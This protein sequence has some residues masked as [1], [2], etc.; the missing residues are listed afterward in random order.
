MMY[1]IGILTIG[2]EVRI[3]QVVNTNAAWLAS[4]LTQTGAFISEHRTIGD[5]REIMLREI[6][7]LFK[8][9][10]L[11]ITTG[12][13]GPTHD[14]ITKPV[15]LEYFND[16]FVFSQDVYNSLLNYL[17]IRN[18]ELTD[19]VKNQAMI[20]SKSQPLENKV[21]TAPG[22]L[23]KKNGKTLIALPGVPAEVKYITTTHIIPYVINEI[24]NLNCEVILY[25]TFITAGTFESDLAE[26]I[27]DVN[28]F[29][30]ESTLAFLPSYEGVRLRIG[31]KANTFEE[32]KIEIDRLSKILYNRVGQYIISENDKNLSQIV[33]EKLKNKNQTVAVA[34]SCTGG[35][36]GKEFTD[37]PGSSAY[38][39]GG[40]IS[41][42]NEAKIKFLNVNKKTLDEFGAVS[43]QTAI[44]MAMNVRDIFNSDYGISITGIA[45]PDGGSP[46]KPVGTVW[47]GISVKNNTFAK[48]FYFGEIREINRK[49]AVGMALTLLLE[50]I[51]FN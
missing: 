36:L 7:D 31:A 23:F 18:R 1:K 14:D 19:L 4:Q 10:D 34:E 39:L 25:K 6:D 40:I 3:G 33:G 2:D 20:P 5:D 22:I 44:E 48:L 43:E 16:K 45:G 29:L 9:N 17:K 47:I 15:L 21:G 46:T 42:S 12:G 38:F 28:K 35:L 11:L 26:K 37:I 8:K 41:Y 24:N 32:A 49:R 50:A 27:G 30:G 13:L 51:N